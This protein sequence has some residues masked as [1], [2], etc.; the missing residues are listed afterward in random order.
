MEASGL[1]DYRADRSDNAAAQSPD[2]FVSYAHEEVDRVRP[3]VA[4]LQNEGYHVFWDRH[5]PAGKRWDTFL[6]EKVRA[7]RCVIVVWSSVSIKS[8]WVCEEAHIAD[9]IGTLVPVCVDDVDPPFGH[10][11]IQAVSLRDGSETAKFLEL[12]E[13]VRSRLLPSSDLPAVAPVIPSR[14]PSVRRR[15]LFGAGAVAV[16]LA[17]WLLPTERQDPPPCELSQGQLDALARKLLRDIQAV[18][19]R[20]TV[21][22]EGKAPFTFLVYQAQGMLKAATIEC[23]DGDWRVGNTFVVGPGIDAGMPRDPVVDLPSRSIALTHCQPA[24]CSDRWRYI[25]YQFELKERFLLEGKGSGATLTVSSPVGLPEKA[26][27][28]YTFERLF[29]ATRG[30]PVDAATLDAAASIFQPPPRH[31]PPVWEAGQGELSRWSIDAAKVAQQLLQRPSEP[32]PQET[33]D[34][35]YRLDVDGDRKPDW[36]FQAHSGQFYAAAGP[37]FLR[38]ILPAPATGA[39]DVYTND[40]SP[41]RMLISGRDLGRESTFWYVF[42]GKAAQ[43]LEPRLATP[44]E[45]HRLDE[46]F[47]RGP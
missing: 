19:V 46:H 45:A 4:A 23:A 32:K 5:I 15:L 26:S 44:Q 41:A 39:L 11:L 3:I 22:T 25:H 14:L 9:K 24:D 28:R 2:I 27:H 47:G 38:S 36:L 16:L 43:A 1:D 20:R 13:E 12:L 37:G 29:Y 6:S 7:A 34:R 30:T 35:V 21:K 10:T 42:D 8:R 31:I 17:G 33:I 18:S 40:A